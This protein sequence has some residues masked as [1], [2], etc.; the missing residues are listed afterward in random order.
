MTKREML[1][2]KLDSIHMPESV[3]SKTLTAMRLQKK[4]ASKDTI[5]RI[6]A[7]A[8]AVVMLLTG[9]VIMWNY[10]FG[11]E[12][13]PPPVAVSPPVST[14]PEIPSPSDDTTPYIP[15]TAEDAYRDVLLDKAEFCYAHSK[16]IMTLNQ[17]LTGNDDVIL[18][19]LRFSVMDLD[20]N[21]T[22][23]VILWL[24]REIDEYYGSIVLRYQDGTVY[25]YEFVYRAMMELKYDG[26]FSFS[27]GASDNGFGMASFTEDT[28]VINKV[29]YCQSEGADRFFVNNER[30]TEDDFLAETYAQDAKPDAAWYD[31][32]E[33]NIELL[34]SSNDDIPDDA[35]SPRLFDPSVLIDI[36]W[37]EETVE[38]TPEVKVFPLTGTYGAFKSRVT[39][40]VTF[41]DENLNLISLPSGTI[42]YAT[43]NNRDG[44]VIAY[45][46]SIEF[47]MDRILMLA[48]G[49]IPT[50]AEGE[51]YLLPYTGEDNFWCLGNTIVTWGVRG[52]YGLY[53]LEERRE[54]LPCEYTQLHPAADG[55]YYANKGGETYLLD[56]GGNVLYSLGYM[57]GDLH[58]NEYSYELDPATQTFWLNTYDKPYSKIECW[59]DYVLVTIEPALFISDR[60]GNV[61]KRYDAAGYVP[62]NGYYTIAGDNLVFMRD[63]GFYVLDKDLNER[64]FPRDFLIPMTDMSDFK[65]PFYYFY[66]DGEIIWQS[67]D[68]IEGLYYY[69]VLSEDGSEREEYIYTFTGEQAIIDRGTL[70]V[71]YDAQGNVLIKHDSSI[72]H[73]SRLTMFGSYVLQ[74]YFNDDPSVWHNEPY[75]VYALN[76]T[77]L[78]DNVFGYISEVTAPGGG[79][80]VYLD[81]N[82]CVLLYPD[83][84]T[85][86]VPN[87]PVVELKY[88]GG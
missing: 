86:P 7:I 33:E 82:T 76:G 85:V 31:F 79:L 10:L 63:D 43:V 13:D 28:Y 37:P 35:N 30:A 9:G 17:F 51:Y 81:E 68:P 45:A 3:Y 50:N 48:D 38:Y 72:S 18:K 87:A 54:V 80:F 26:T 47:Y 67:Y 5:T 16:E 61:I 11:G 15:Q 77:L 57:P 56:C 46:L 44:N 22:P 78:L 34:L 8:A 24:A 23:E 19:V 42:D 65:T 14:S 21:G 20:Q 84:R 83:G 75:A 32:T 70:A 64:H 49:A 12:N 62:A 40:E 25:G 39:G 29:T 74:E 60:D 71:M 41:V 1:E 59:G 27:S 55:I 58:W 36:D 88:Y 73:S 52:S 6:A 53:N 4:R 66:S 2:Q 69:H